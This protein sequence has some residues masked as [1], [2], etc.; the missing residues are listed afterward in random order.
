MIWPSNLIEIVV[1][2]NTVTLT[3]WN[4]D[5]I[6]SQRVA[7]SRRCFTTISLMTIRTV[8]IKLWMRPRTVDVNMWFQEMSKKYCDLTSIRMFRLIEKSLIPLFSHIRCKCIV[9]KN[10]K[11]EFEV[12]LWYICFVQFANMSYCYYFTLHTTALQSLKI[13]SVFLS[14]E[15]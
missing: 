3:V 10:L 2:V 9:L 13:F 14:R 6:L 8:Y 1:V 11:K 7:T 12:S 15:V 5:T 4:Y